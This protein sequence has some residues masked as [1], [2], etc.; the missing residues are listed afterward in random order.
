MMVTQNFRGDWSNYSRGNFGNISPLTNA[1]LFGR[2]AFYVNTDLAVVLWD[3]SRSMIQTWWVRALPDARIAISD[4][5]LGALYAASTTRYDHGILGD[6]LEGEMAVIYNPETLSETRIAL[7]DNDVF[8]GVM[9]FWADID[10]DGTHDLVTTVSNVEVGARIRVYRTDGTM[11]AEGDPINEGDHWRHQLAFGA[12]GANGEHE[13][14]TVRT[15]DTGGVV[16]YYRYQDGKLVLT[17]EQPGY[18]SHVANTRNLDLAVAGD[19]NGDGQLEIVLPDQERHTLN[20]LQR[21]MDGVAVVWSVSLDG[22]LTSNLAAITLTNESLALAAGTDK[23]IIQVW[24]SQF[25]PVPEATE[26]SAGSG[27]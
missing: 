27:S 25:P 4:T 23:G 6:N 10:E 9:P 5:G 21:T 14:V 3:N 19:F 15:P 13:L 26:E 20:A 22:A 8:E 2:Y 7:P 1:G 24:Q 18:T 11:L 12:F 16:E 17:A